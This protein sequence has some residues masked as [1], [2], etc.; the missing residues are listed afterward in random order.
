MNSFTVFHTD[1]NGKL[2]VLVNQSKKDVLVLLAN[3]NREIEGIY[4]WL[5]TAKRGDCYKFDYEVVVCTNLDC[6]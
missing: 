6:T 5:D 4:D 2:A 1:G 3:R